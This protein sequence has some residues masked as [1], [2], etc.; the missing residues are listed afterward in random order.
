MAKCGAGFLDQWCKAVEFFSPLL[1]ISKLFWVHMGLFVLVVS[2]SY[3]SSRQSSSGDNDMSLD[4]AI[5]L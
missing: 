2:T 5:Y 1:C 3:L 4:L